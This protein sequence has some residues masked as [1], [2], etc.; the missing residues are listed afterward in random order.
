MGEETTTRIHR[1]RCVE[2]GFET[3]AESEAWESADHPTLGTLTKCPECGST[4]T[5]NR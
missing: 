4:N 2:C 3:P 1:T 5:T